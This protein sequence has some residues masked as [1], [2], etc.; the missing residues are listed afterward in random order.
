[1]KSPRPTP[2]GSAPTIVIAL[3]A[4]AMPPK[5]KKIRRGRPEYDEDE[6]EMED[7]EDDDMPPLPPM[8]TKGRDG[9]KRLALKAKKGADGMKIGR[10]DGGHGG[11]G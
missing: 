6:D 8:V 9:K 4:P 2:P 10:K 7:E 3:G 1:M 5:G 11:R